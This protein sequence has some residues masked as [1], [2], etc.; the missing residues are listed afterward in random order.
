MKHS[1][2]RI[3]TSHVGSLIR[4]QALQAHLRARAAGPGYDAQAHADCLRESVAEVVRE[5]ARVGIDV[6]SDG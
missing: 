2:R 6:V 3:L 1:T 4:P 5:Q